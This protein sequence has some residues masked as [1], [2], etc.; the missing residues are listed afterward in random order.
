MAQI[1]RYM[2]VMITSHFIVGDHNVHVSIDLGH[3]VELSW[4]ALCSPEQ[5]LLEFQ[6]DPRSE[7]EIGRNVASCP[8]QDKVHQR[9]D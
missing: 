4:T 5:S 1:Y 8:S 9:V 3:S 2:D 6:I 7:I